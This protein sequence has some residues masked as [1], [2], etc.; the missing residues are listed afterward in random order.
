[1]RLLQAA[2]AAVPRFAA[3]PCVRSWHS[4]AVPECPHSRRVLEGKRTNYGHWT[5]GA[6]ELAARAA[7]H[8]AADRAASQ[9]QM[10]KARLIEIGSDVVGTRKNLA[11]DSIF[12]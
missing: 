4:A 1:M 11:V 6:D 5:F 3:L 9:R 8:R 2:A 12:A 10:A 7:T